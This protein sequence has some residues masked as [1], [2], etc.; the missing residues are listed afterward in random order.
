[1]DQK[2]R[3]SELPNVRSISCLAVHTVYPSISA[4][5][6]SAI[7]TYS[8]LIELTALI[9]RHQCSALCPPLPVRL[10][11]ITEPSG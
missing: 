4:S 3:G 10:R 9:V 1:M 11:A 7:S 8:S 5:N 6:F 2:M